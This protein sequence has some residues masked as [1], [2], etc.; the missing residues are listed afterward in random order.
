MKIFH[1]ITQVLRENNTVLTIGTFDGF[2]VGHRE[3]IKQVLTDAR[4]TGGRSFV[5]TF[6]PHPRSVVS[7]DFKMGLLSTLEEKIEL[8]EQSGIENLLVINFTPE[9]SKLTYEDFFL[10][11]IVGKIGIRQL[12]IGHDHRLGKNRGGD[13]NKLVEL[14][15]AHSFTVVPVPAVKVDD[16]PVSST[17]IRHALEE[18]N[19]KRAN[20]FL[21]RNYS[22]SGSIVKGAMRGRTLGFPTANVK[23]DNPDKMIPPRGVYAVEF[24]AEG[25]KHYGVMNIG[26]RPTF[27]DA[28]ELIIEVYIFNFNGDLYGSKAKVGVIARLR[29]EKRFNSAEELVA[30]IQKDKSDAMNIINQLNN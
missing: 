22:F 24:I 15:T 7:K 2:H 25:Q 17:R 28:V 18:G 10:N 11:Y 3:I 13:E 30:Q 4:K 23:V 26:M 29:E 1:D 6:E 12:V 27:A 16:Q 19:I 9:F 20:S 21:G 14:G 8:I 5:I